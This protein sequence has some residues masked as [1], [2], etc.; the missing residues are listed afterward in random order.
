MKRRFEPDA[1]QKLLHPPVAAVDET[2][3]VQDQHGWQ[4]IEKILLRRVD[5][6]AGGGDKVGNE[7]GY[8]KVI[9]SI[10]D[11]LDIVR[12]RKSKR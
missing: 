5:G 8:R 10:F 1:L 2:L 7:F 4:G 6:S 3:E 12:L 11:C 9:Q